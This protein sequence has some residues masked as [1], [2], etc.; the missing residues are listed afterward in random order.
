MEC[1]GQVA[2]LRT[3]LTGAPR[4][5]DPAVASAQYAQKHYL[6]TTEMSSSRPVRRPRVYDT[7]KDD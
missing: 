5:R 4:L 7:F 2:S 3:H 1:G 6:P